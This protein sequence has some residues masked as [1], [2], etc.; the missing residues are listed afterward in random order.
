[1]VNI[2]E[3]KPLHLLSEV[4]HYVVVDNDGSIV[5]AKHLGSGIVVD[6]SVK[7]VKEL[8][9]SADQ[10]SKTV[11]VGKEDKHWTEKQIKD[12]EADGTL[13]A[14]HQVRVGDVRLEGI[15]TIWENIHSAQA[16]AVGYIKQEKILSGKALKAARDKQAD[17]ALAKITA[18]QKAKKGVAKAALEA[19]Q[20][21]QEKPILPVQEGE[22]RTLRGYKIQFTSRDGRYDC[23]DI[24]LPSNDPAKRIRPVNINTIKW[25]IFDDVRYE[26]E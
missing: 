12:A 22:E 9:K 2:A 20:E 24:D 13:K 8:T 4:A 7:Y 26:V 21:I 6:L 18:A 5:K 17:E 19:I 25:L 15:R 16:L 11:K 1:M 10:Y 23:I 14:G 3:V